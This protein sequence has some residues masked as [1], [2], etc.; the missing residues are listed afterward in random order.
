M[1]HTAL[2]VS[3]DALEY[4]KSLKAAG[5]IDG[6][7]LDDLEAVADDSD[8]VLTAGEIAEIVGVVDSRIRQLAPEMAQEG[9][10]IKKGRDWR[11]SSGAARW[12]TDRPDGRTR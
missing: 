11:F 9:L 6:E 8:Y 1:T 10:A 2:K 3:P 12:I 4:F 5:K 7:W